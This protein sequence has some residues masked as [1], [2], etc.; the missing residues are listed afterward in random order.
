MNNLVNCLDRDT[1]H[2]AYFFWRNHIR[3]NE[4]HHIA[5][6]TQQHA[7]GKG[8][9]ENLQATAFAPVESCPGFLVLHQ[10]HCSDHAGL[11]DF[12]Y[13]GVTGQWC[14]GIGH[15]ARQ[16]AIFFQNIVTGKNIEGG[17]GGTRRQRVTG[18]AV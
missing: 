14:K 12:E 15:G 2:Q 7:F 8:V 1:D 3:R 10:L 5:N 17:K 9:F 6:R 11:A 13:M 4:I 16:P 18:I